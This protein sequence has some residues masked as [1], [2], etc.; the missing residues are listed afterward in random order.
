M[1][2]GRVPPGHEARTTMGA[3]ARRQAARRSPRAAGPDLYFEEDRLPA[4]P[5]PREEMACPKS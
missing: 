4:T 1:P 3:A 5:A 2:A